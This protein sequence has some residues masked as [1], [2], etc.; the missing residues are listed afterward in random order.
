M[1]CVFCGFSQDLKYLVSCN[2]FVVFHVDTS[3]KFVSWFAELQPLRD[4]ALAPNS[5]HVESHLRFVWI[6]PRIWVVAS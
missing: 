6:L 3:C 1:L 2:G 5:E 4:L